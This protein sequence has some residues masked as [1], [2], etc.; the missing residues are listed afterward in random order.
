M[1]RP[2][3]PLLSAGN[4]DDIA[5]ARAPGE[6]ADPTRRLLADRGREAGHL[7]RPPAEQGCEA[8]IPTTRSR[9][10]PIPCDAEAGKAR[11]LMEGMWRSMMDGRRNATG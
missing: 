9:R 8:I 5:V 10:G 6:A 7:R 2:R 4:T 11:N 1:C 3:V